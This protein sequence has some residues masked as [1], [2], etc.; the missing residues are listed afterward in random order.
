MMWRRMNAVPDCAGSKTIL[1]P[2]EQG[3][4]IINET[5]IQQYI[6]SL[7]KNEKKKETRN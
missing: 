1:L 2:E 7:K 3:G 5:G 4:M 6:G